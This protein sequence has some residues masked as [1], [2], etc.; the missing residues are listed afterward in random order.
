MDEKFLVPLVAAFSTVCGILLTQFFTLFKE[1]IISKREKNSLFREKYE[2]L[3]T[4]LSDSES[5]KL[6]FNN[7]E[8][9][10]IFSITQ[11]KSI[12]NIIVLSYLYFPELIEP[13]RNYYN[14]YQNYVKSTLEKF[15]PDTGLSAAMQAATYA[16][17][18]MELTLNK[19]HD[20]QKKLY[21][22]LR[23]YAPK[24]ARA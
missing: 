5:H 15:I 11:N 12:D 16:D 10:E 14:A 8:T 7:T 2:Q 18:N 20:S 13:S 6:I 23:K 3:A 22:C 24:Y 19:L 21:D 4:N 1:S 9:E 17:E